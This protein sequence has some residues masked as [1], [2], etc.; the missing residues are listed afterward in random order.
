MA[1]GAA[2]T[3][4][5]VEEAALPFDRRRHGLILGMGAVA[6]VVEGA[7][8]AERRGVV[9]IAE[10]LGASIVNSAFHG[11]RLDVEHIAGAMKSLVDDV[12]A[13]EG[14]TPQDFARNAIFMSHETYTPA[15]GGSAAA[16]IEALRA[17][18]GDAAS[19][20][21]VS[22]TKGF[23]GHPMGAGIED[24]VVVKALQ[25]GVVPPV[26]NLREPDEQLGNLTLSSGQRRPF[27][28]AVR[29][30]AGFGSQLAL[31][32]HKAVA[33]GDQRVADSA[34]RLAWLKQITGYTHV[35]EVIEDRTLRAREAAAD[36]PYDLKPEVSPV[37]FLGLP[38]RSEPPAAVVPAPA[39][40]VPSAPAAPAAPVSAPGDVLND[41]IAVVAERTG[42][43]TSEIEPDF[44]LEADL[45]IDTVKQAE[46]LS[47]LT[48]RYGIERN[49]DFRL[50]DY[51]TIEALAGYLATASG[52]APAPAPA[53]ASAPAPAA[54]APMAPVAPSVAESP[55]ALDDLLQVVSEK[56]GY[57][58]AELEPD[59]ELEADLGIDTV[60]QAEILGDLTDR[61]GL[62]RDEEFRLSDYPTLQA[63]AGY[64][65][66]RKAGGTV[67]AALPRHRR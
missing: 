47:E 32:V 58:V 9:P 3:H 43:E 22:N 26:A 33:Q 44:E 4:D 2:T 1:A 17:A 35:E 34:R 49:D 56:T 16:E 8:A 13:R 50:A 28:Y 6:M 65:S 57:D 46:I 10:Q 45:G 21:V 39:P 48:D 59:F 36:A 53:P 20:I 30:A 64:L 38:T 29:L 19:D 11:T 61:Y 67:V 55:D 18:F 54:A 40:A 37:D 62:E 66:A 5:V 60:K 23:T 41:L 63:L 24:G 15:R 27:R 31:T 51:P 12:C 52:G 42:Y 14:V 25:Y 7:Q